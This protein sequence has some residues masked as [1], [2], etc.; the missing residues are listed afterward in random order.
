MFEGTDLNSGS[1][2]RTEAVCQ[3]GLVADH[4]ATRLTDALKYTTTHSQHGARV[5]ET[6]ESLY[7]FFFN[8][9]HG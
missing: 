4:Q 5:K 1:N 7:F 8:F 6:T 9:P 3:R 2:F